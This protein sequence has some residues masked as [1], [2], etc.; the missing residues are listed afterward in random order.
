MLVFIMLFSSRHLQ[1]ATLTVLTD[2]HF[3][4]V[5]NHLSMATIITLIELKLIKDLSLMPTLASVF[6]FIVSLPPPLT[7][8]K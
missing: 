6:C 8:Q 4:F 7:S 2:L 1:M 3:I 5:F